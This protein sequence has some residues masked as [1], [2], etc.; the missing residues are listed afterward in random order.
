MKFKKDGR[1]IVTEIDRNKIF[2]HFI[3]NIAPKVGRVTS[4]PGRIQEAIMVD[5]QWYG[6][7]VDDKNPNMTS[8]ELIPLMDK[9]IL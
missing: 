9:E 6:L 2:N 7:F 4:G 3:R 1:I 8:D 5:K